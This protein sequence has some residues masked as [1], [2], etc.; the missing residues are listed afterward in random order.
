MAEKQSLDSLEKNGVD[1]KNTTDQVSTHD[2]QDNPDDKSSN[3]VES[4]HILHRIVFAA[5]AGAAVFT[6]LYWPLLWLGVTRYDEE[7]EIGPEWVLY[8][9]YVPSYVGAMG[10]LRGYARLW[11]RRTGTGMTANVGGGEKE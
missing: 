5:L 3:P 7:G 2:S 6:C 9:C 1:E 8:C 10:L 4:L 11:A